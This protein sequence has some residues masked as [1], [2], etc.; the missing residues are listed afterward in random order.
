MRSTEIRAEELRTRWVDDIEGSHLRHL[1]HI[2]QDVDDLE[3]KRWL[4][5]AMRSHLR[6]CFGELTRRE[7]QRTVAFF[8]CLLEEEAAR[9]ARIEAHEQDLARHR[10]ARLGWSIK[11]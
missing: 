3:H 7:A 8:F 2:T 5:P 1:V 10:L 4:A 6:A 9:A 11:G